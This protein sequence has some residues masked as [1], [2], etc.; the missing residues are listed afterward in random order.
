MFVQTLPAAARQ[1]LT[2]LG[3]IPLMHPFYLAGGSAAALH[4]GHRI[5]VDL[6]FFTHQPQYEVDLLVQQ[7]QAIGHLNVQQQNQNTLIGQ[8]RDVRLSF[9]SYPYPL[10]TEPAS[11]EN[12]Q[13]AQLLDIALMK[14]VAISQRGTKRDFVDLYFICQHGYDLAQLLQQTSQKYPSIT[15]PSYHLLRALVYFAD[16]EGDETPQMLVPF[17][18]DQVKGFF[19]DRVKRLTRA[20]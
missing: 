3:Q 4:L 19:Q 20:L 2:Q 11:W 12:V 7:L 17:D 9:F 18:W 8:L 5:S 15:Y 1:L 14:L 13:I 6:D 10:L 16:A